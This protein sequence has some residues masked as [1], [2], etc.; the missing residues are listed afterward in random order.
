[1]KNCDSHRRD[2]LS[3]FTP[4]SIEINGHRLSYLDEGQGP[5]IVMMHGNPTWSFYYRNLVLTLRDRYRL[6]VPDHLG[7]GL[8]DKPQHYPYRLKNH[9]D[10]AESLL[11]RLGVDD[12]SMVVHDWG[13][14]IG[15][16]VAGRNPSRLKA[17]LVL[18]TAAFR[19]KRI[20]GRIR[21]C[22]MPVLG[23]FLVR[24]LNAF[25][26]G[27]VSMAVSRKMAPEVAR[28][29]LAPY[30][31]WA[32]RVAVLRFVQ[33]IP[34]SER[35]ASWPTLM[36]VEAG[37]VHF[38]S[39]PMLILWGGRDFCFNVDFFEEWKKRFPQAR[40]RLF[41]EAGHY[42]LE[43]A[44]EEIGPLAGSFFDKVLLRSPGRMG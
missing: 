24:G 22:R 15:M 27:A 35:D 14:A 12:F 30:D 43:D 25:A 18:N 3:P 32:N 16:G 4:K 44:F 6:I 29:Y 34:L 13:G 10:N 21:L 2:Y 31:S 36:E 28:G 37:L 42:V 23:D 40:S 33:D 5:V 17:L 8:S 9:I 39:T 41:A 26:G 1:M 7:C 11:E 38:R 20:P 19:S